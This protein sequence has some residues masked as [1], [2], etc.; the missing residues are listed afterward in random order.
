MM[1]S[2]LR[3]R[4][5]PKDIITR[6]I[7]VAKVGRLTPRVAQPL[8]GRN[9][10]S[11]AFRGQK[12]SASQMTTSVPLLSCTVCISTSLE[13]PGFAFLEYWLFTAL[14]RYFKGV[15]FHLWQRTF[16][17]RSRQRS[18]TLWFK[19]IDSKPLKYKQ[20]DKILWDSFWRLLHSVTL[21]ESRMY[22]KQRLSF[23]NVSHKLKHLQKR[24]MTS[25][26]RRQTFPI[27][28][29]MFNLFFAF[30]QANRL[31]MPLYEEIKA[32]FRISALIFSF[33]TC[34]LIFCI[35]VEG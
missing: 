5:G 10:K 7:Y 34:W 12:A 31:K 32:T 30:L 21:T 25:W 29:Y 13:E 16:S 9:N 8:K 4:F 26:T 27:L 14:R 28:C 22:S 11:I 18:K 20:I 2:V 23:S 35:S 19:K 33:C 6:G 24:A 15:H 3:K 1:V 17:K